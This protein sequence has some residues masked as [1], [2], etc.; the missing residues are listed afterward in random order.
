MSGSDDT[1]YRVDRAHLP[2]RWPTHLCPADFWEEL[3][4]TIAAFGFLEDSLQ[5]ANLAITAT[6]EYKSVQEAEEAFKT[7]ERDLELS[8]DETLGALVNRFVTA[9]KDD[10]RYSPR[11]E[12]EIGKRLKDV[13]WWRNA[14][15][16]G[17][18]TDYD[19]KSGL[20]ALRYWPRGKWS[21]QF[22][23][24]DR[25]LSRGDLAR[26][27]SAAI[28]IAIAVI[29]AVTTRG[30]AFPGTESPGRDVAAELGGK[31]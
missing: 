25:R 24:G 13:A 7:W 27:R 23:H 20:A 8:M 30:I 19:A 12:Q 10:E 26:I 17:A 18:W 1:G 14:L 21:E 9:L 16:H 11:D 6:R 3:G 29:D 4:R 5:R 22:E 28:E 31:T 2:D 15:C